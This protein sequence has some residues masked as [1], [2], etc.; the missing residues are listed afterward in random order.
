MTES[1]EFPGVDLSDEMLAIEVIPQKDDAFTC[2][3]CSLVRRRSEIAAGRGGHAS[4]LEC[5][6]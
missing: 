4:C 3:S 5:E 2:C 6:G 1:V